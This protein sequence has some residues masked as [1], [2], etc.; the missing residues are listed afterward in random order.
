[1]RIG[2][3]IRNEFGGEGRS[4]GW[5]VGISFYEFIGGREEREVV[6]FGG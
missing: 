2:W 6:G 4:V 5:S 1:M 3:E